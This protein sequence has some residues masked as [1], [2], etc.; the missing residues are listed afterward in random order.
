MDFGRQIEFHEWAHRRRC[1]RS[2]VDSCSGESDIT[3]SISVAQGLT[4]PI[5]FIIGPLAIDGVLIVRRF[6]AGCRIVRGR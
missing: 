4:L 6:Q 1:M 3:T 2:T 5:G